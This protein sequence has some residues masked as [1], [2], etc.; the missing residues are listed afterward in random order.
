M[1]TENYFNELHPFSGILYMIILLGTVITADYGWEMLIVFVLVSINVIEL[2]GVCAYFK[3]LRVY[4]VI[5]IATALFNLIFNHRGNTPFLYVNDIPLTVDSL[6]YGLF[7]GMMIATLLM[8]FLMFNKFFDNRKIVYLIGGK[9]PSIALI[10]SMVFCFYEKFL[11]KIDRIKEV[12]RTFEKT[13]RLSK[14]KNAGI[15][16]SV[17]LSAMIED[18]VDTAK[19][20]NARAYGKYKRTKYVP[21]KIRLDDILIL[22]V[23]GAMTICLWQIQTPVRYMIIGTFAI[24]PTIYN[25]YKEIQWKFYLWKI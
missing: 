3:S 11:Y 2:N 19:S 21:Y 25:I 13:G 20:M 4:F 17:L 24:V 1:E 10:I 6:I 5:M 22:V 7:T 23:T 18:S 9:F 12:W 15:V 16:L 8:W 14:I